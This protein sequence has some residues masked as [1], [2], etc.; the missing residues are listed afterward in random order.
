MFILNF[1][2]VAHEAY[3]V[4][5]PCK[6]KFKEILNSDDEKYGGCG[7]LNQKPIVARKRKQPTGKGLKKKDTYE[8]EMYLPPLSAIVLEYD[9]QG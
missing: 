8:L 2:P 5:A 7:R 9:Y 1:T 3:T 6:G 4:K